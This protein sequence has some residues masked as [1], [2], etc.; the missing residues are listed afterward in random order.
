VR[1]S[2]GP[3]FRDWHRRFAW[4]PVRIDKEWVWLE[5]VERRLVP[6]GPD[7][8]AV[9]RSAL[10]LPSVTAYRNRKRNRADGGYR[11]TVDQGSHHAPAFV[12]NQPSSVQ[13]PTRP[14]PQNEQE[15][16]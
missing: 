7:W 16:P 12:P 5:W 10:G 14:Q 15:M 4:R 11:P 3:D 1:W 9:W 8:A 6:D 2:T 13:P